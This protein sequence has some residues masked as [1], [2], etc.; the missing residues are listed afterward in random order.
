[1]LLRILSSL[2]QLIMLTREISFYNMAILSSFDWQQTYLPCSRYLNSGEKG[3]SALP[4]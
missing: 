1:M 3:I 4:L 2:L